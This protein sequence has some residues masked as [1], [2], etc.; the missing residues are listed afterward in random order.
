M[1]IS[2]S[3]IASKLTILKSIA[4]SKGTQSIQGVLFKD[5]KLT[6]YNLSIGITAPLSTDTQ[7]QFII[8]TKAIEMI[9]KLPDGELEIT[10]DDEVILLKVGGVKSKYITTPVSDFPEVPTIDET[11]KSISLDGVELQNHISAVMYAVPDSAPK[12]I[13]NGVLLESSGGILNIVACDGARISHSKMEYPGEFQMVVPKA[14]MQKLLSI[15]LSG[16]V[17][18]IYSANKVIFKT[19]EFSM[20]TRLL[21]GEFLDYKSATPKNTIV[22]EIDRKTIV[23][24]LS[25]AV[26][27]VDDRSPLPIEAHFSGS[28]VSLKI[29]S[30]LSEYSETIQLENPISKPVRIGLNTR[31]FLE[32]LKSFDAG[33]IR[34]TLESETSPI[35]ISEG[36]LFTILLPVRLKEAQ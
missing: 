35:T 1:K 10:A 22:T 29:N 7:E 5:N 28:E 12:A 4:Q 26:L 11:T 33:D 3:E 24:S 30:P 27:C 17:E 21:E 15:G 8:P 19:N 34:L 2:K 31:F 32:C 9:E 36:D 25:R 23:N 18:I 16:D 14:S 13:M 20:F 6:A